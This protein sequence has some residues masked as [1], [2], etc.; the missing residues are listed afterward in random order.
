MTRSMSDDTAVSASLLRGVIKIN[1]RRSTMKTHYQIIR[2]GILIALSWSIAGCTPAPTPEQKRNKV[3]CKQEL[4]YSTDWSKAWDICTGYIALKKDGSL[5]QLGEVGGCN[6][7]QMLPPSD[8]KTGKPTHTTK[9]IYHLA[10]KKIGDGFDGAKM[11]NGISRL[12]AIKKDGTLWGWG[13]G[14]G[15]KPKKLSASGNWAD[16]SVKDGSQD[17]YDYD[18]GLKKDGTLWRITNKL[19][20]VSRFS[21]WNKIT[22]GCGAI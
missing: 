4:T 2:F 17:C 10:P 19:Q 20:K 15:I 5:W 22:L 14:L 21:D 9:Y 18:I 6:R 11:I 12:Y 8:P 3:P 16:F 7:G 1:L 13:K